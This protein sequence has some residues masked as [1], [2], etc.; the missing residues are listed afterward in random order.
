M[1]EK[2]ARYF[3]KEKDSRALLE[4]ASIKLKV[5]LRQILAGKP[6]FE[7]VKMDFADVFLANGRPLLVEAAGTL[8]P[9]L[10]FVELFPAMPRLVVDMGAIPHLCKGADVMVPGVRRFD[11]DFDKGDLV[12]VVD[13]K[14]RKAVAIGEALIDS[15]EAKKASRGAIVKNIHFVGDKTWNR[16]RDLEAKIKPDSRIHETFL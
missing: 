15:E 10:V 7:V 2:N 9:T 5:D 1:P 14:H 16:I 8:H 11:G 3:L 6:S 13:E 12:V 4:R